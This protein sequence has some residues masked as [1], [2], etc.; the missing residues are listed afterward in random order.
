[1]TTKMLKMK[2]GVR[3]FEDELVGG[4]PPTVIHR[5]Y[6]VTV[7]WKPSRLYQGPDLKAAKKIFEEAA[8]NGD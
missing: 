5:Q 3:L 1:M 6:T 8:F 2:S 4:V 7:T